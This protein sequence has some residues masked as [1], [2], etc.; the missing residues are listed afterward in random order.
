M[1]EPKLTMNARGASAEEVQ[2]GV[3]AALTVFARHNTT[4]VEVT[5]AL[6]A[7][8]IDEMMGAFVPP[9]LMVAGV[10]PAEPTTTARQMQ[11]ADIW[12]EA[13]KAA[14][15]AC[16]SGAREEPRDAQLVLLPPETQNPAA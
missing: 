4:A 8:N 1:T 12:Y 2:R 7:R 3:E 9:E 11:I 6:A 14:A 15:N 10:N 5:D 16:Y 13:E